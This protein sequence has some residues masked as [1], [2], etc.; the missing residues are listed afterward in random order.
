[1]DWILV[2]LGAGAGSVLRYEISRQMGRYMS[3]QHHSLKTFGTFA[4]NLSGAF[5]LGIVVAYSNEGICWS[6]LADG[7]LGGFTT[8]STFMVEGVILIRGNQKMNA[9]VYFIAT[10][11]L[12]I[13]A[14][15]L[16]NI[17]TG[18]IYS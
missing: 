5:L 13:V 4:V 10:V 9:M 12:G 6:L 15:F 1:M 7:F 8:F 11:F 2:G 18:W 3:L 17:L 14:F 16:G